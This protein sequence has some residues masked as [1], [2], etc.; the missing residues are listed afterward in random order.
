VV[1]VEADGP[2]DLPETDNFALMVEECVRKKYGSLWENIRITQVFELGTVAPSEIKDDGFI[3]EWDAYYLEAWK[4]PATGLGRIRTRI[5]RFKTDSALAPARPGAIEQLI[6][7]LQRGSPTPIVAIQFFRYIRRS[8][9]P[10]SS[11][12]SQ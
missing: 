1:R 5:G 2:K 12:A 4:D 8:K 10:N 11:F 7:S 3:H 6:S 9:N